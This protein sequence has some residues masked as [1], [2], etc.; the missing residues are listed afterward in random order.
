MT[1]EELEQR[2][3]ARQEPRDLPRTMSQREVDAY[4]AATADLDARI[5]S[6]RE[7]QATLAKL[8]SL[9]DD[10]TWVAHLTA[11]RAALCADLLEIRSPIRDKETRAR[12]DD[13]TF[14]IRLIDGFKTTLPVVDLSS[15][16]IGRFMAEAGYAVV[17]EALHG[18]RGWRGS[19]P[20]VERRVKQ[21]QQ[22][23]AAA[24]HRLA[25]ALLDDDARAKRDAEAAARRQ[26]LDSMRLR[27]SSN[28]GPYKLV[29]V[30]SDGTAMI[31]LD[32]LSAAQRE[33]LDH[34][35]AAWAADNT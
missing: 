21:Q 32:E 10:L 11:W 18:P 16:R 28:G 6:A 27:G 35:N 1:L 29:P 19:L 17:G 9:D 25:D 26:T 14:S 24:E 4:V 34:A 23:R 20:D 7:A 2:R 3:T 12:S 13:L 8:A 5:H 22:Q 15:T 31:D 30:R 33:A